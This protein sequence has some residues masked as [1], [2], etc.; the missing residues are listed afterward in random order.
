MEE[1]QPYALQNFFLTTSPRDGKTNAINLAEAFNAFFIDEVNYRTE[2]DILYNDDKDYSDYASNF[3]LPSQNLTP[4]KV[5]RILHSNEN[6]TAYIFSKRDVEHFVYSM[7]SSIARMWYDKRLEMEDT[8]LSKEQWELFLI[9]LFNDKFET[10]PSVPFLRRKRRGGKKKR[11][12]KRV[13]KTRRRYR[14]TRI[15]RN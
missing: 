5:L 7:I 11:T 10:I 4:E 3:L 14:K 8:P 13:K 12:Q 2:N 9:D 6:P 15:R 1:I